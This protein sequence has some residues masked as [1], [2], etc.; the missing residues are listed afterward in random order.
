MTPSKPV[1]QPG[2][3]LTAEKLKTLDLL[4]NMFGETDEWGGAES[5]GSD[6]DMDDVAPQAVD[7]VDNAPEAVPE[8]PSP[9]PS[10]TKKGATRRADSC[11]A[12]VQ[13][14]KISLRRARTK[15]RA[16]I[17]VLN[18]N[19]RPN[20]PRVHTAGFSATLT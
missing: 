9:E 8:P 10:P 4:K 19:G 20:G 15:M 2:D 12:Q 5:V 11:R 17:C 1:S 6:V 18:S 7:A 3:S 14:L 13:N 16:L